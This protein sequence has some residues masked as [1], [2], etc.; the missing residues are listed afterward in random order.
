MNSKE[1]LYC[2]CQICDCLSRDNKLYFL[3]QMNAK[4][5]SV[6][7]HGISVLRQSW[8]Y[9]S[10]SYSFILEK[11]LGKSECD[12]CQFAMFWC[13]MQTQHPCTLEYLIE[14]SSII[15]V[16]LLFGIK[17]RTVYV[18]LKIVLQCTGTISQYWVSSFFLPNWGS[19]VLPH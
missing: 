18:R 19:K 8:K 17:M 12:G 13:F 9:F 7:C 10:T 6:S 4:N 2:I 3:L 15:P 14:T 16:A 1:M 5:T 11:C